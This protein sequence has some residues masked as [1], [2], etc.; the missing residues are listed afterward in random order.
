MPIQDKLLRTGLSKLTI[1]STA[2][3]ALKLF[4]GYRGQGGYIV[5]GR[6]PNSKRFDCYHVSNISERASYNLSFSES[7]KL[8][9]ARLDL[10]DEVWWKDNADYD[11]DYRLDRLLEVLHDEMPS[12]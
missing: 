3:K 4:D 7:E 10:R 9:I 6:I 1:H 11:P 12:V 2:K 5:I 8:V